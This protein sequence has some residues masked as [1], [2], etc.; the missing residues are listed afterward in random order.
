MAVINLRNVDDALVARLKREAIDRSM[1][2]HEYCVSR[3]DGPSAP[4]PTTPQ[5]FLHDLGI[6]TQKMVTIPIE[7]QPIRELTRVPIDDI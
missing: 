6:T 3:L 5:Q 7:Q 2:F 4:P 1:G